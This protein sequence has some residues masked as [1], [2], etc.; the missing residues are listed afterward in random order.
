M[1][2]RVRV[3]VRVS[4]VWFDFTICR[5]DERVRVFFLV[6]R[7]PCSFHNINGDFGKLTISIDIVRV[8]IYAC[9]LLHV[10]GTKTS[11]S[12]I[13]NSQDLSRFIL[14]FCSMRWWFMKS[15]P[16]I[17]TNQTYKILGFIF[18]LSYTICLFYVY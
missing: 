16:F 15:K 8:R 1:Y 4:N 13:E 5:Q 6:F 12:S 17:N 11:F 10:V 7:K 14:W 9:Q 3:N 18:I 2:V